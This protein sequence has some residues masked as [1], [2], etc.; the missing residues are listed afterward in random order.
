MC[1]IG[2][3]EKLS[4]IQW[5]HIVANSAYLKKTFSYTNRIMILW[6]GK[7]V[8]ISINLQRTCITHY[9]LYSHPKFMLIKHLHQDTYLWVKKNDPVVWA[10]AYDLGDQ[11]PE[12][13]QISCVTLGNFIVFLCLSFTPGK[14][15][16]LVLARSGVKIN[17]YKATYSM[18]HLC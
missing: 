10:L 4:R 13:L 14:M 18:G 1:F 7:K 3:I 15:G 17:M 5:F 2:S 12:L 16:I 11:F 8:Y 6:C 9:W